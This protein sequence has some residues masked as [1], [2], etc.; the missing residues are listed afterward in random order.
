M[1]RLALEWEKQSGKLKVRQREQLRRALT[2]AAN[3]L[4]WE[5]AS[6]KELDAI[7]RDITKL[8]RAGTRA[9]RRD[10]ERETK[11]KRKEIDLLKA[12][13]KTLR[14]VAEDAES[15]YPVEFSYS[16]T[17]RSPARGLVTK[18]E[19]LT[20]ADADEAGAAADNVEKRTETWDKLR[21]EM[22]EE[23]KVREKQ[24]ADLSGSLSSFAKAAQGTVKEI[25]AIL[26]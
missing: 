20:L 17:A 22:I 10:L 4:S 18:T 16:Y 11:I 24:W 23:L 21:L 6:E 9:I 7:T 12:A 5:G 19:P 15:D 1:A 8:A 2:V 3:I 25:L 26:T 13:V 14:K